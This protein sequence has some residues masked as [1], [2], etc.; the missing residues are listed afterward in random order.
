M[1][2]AIAQSVIVSHGARGRLGGSR[3][4]KDTPAL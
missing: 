1:Y 2:P 4:I 3:R